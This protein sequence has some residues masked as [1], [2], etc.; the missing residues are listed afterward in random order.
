[1]NIDLRKVLNL[2]D[3]KLE[4]EYLE[5]L[6][7]VEFNGNVPA[8]NPVNIKGFIENR[9][10]VVYLSFSVNTI[11]NLICD[12]CTKEFNK[13]FSL[14]I[15][16]VLTNSVE[17]ES[18]MDD[19]VI[20]LDG[21]MLDLSDVVRS[22]FILNIDTKN[23]CKDDCKGLCQVCGKD[24]NEGSCGCNDRFVNPDFAKLKDLFK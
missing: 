5:D 11:L 18:E 4:F 22:D 12:R 16:H 24:L 14:Q 6:S 20:L 8:V 10:G 13:T 17:N 19:N 9:A 2:T 23:L 3:S 21:H 15:N 7:D 1:M